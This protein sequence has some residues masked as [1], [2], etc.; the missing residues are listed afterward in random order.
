[1]KGSQM[2]DIKAYIAEHIKFE[3]VDT[4]NTIRY[5]RTGWFTFRQEHNDNV[6]YWGPLIVRVMQK[7]LEAEWRLFGNKSTTSSHRLID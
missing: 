7:T 2:N 4:I 1:M 3:P 5:G 6:A